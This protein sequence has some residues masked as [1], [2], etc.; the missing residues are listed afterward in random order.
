QGE[1]VAQLADEVEAAVGRAPEVLGEG[2]VRIEADRAGVLEAAPA[3]GRDLQVQAGRR[4]RAA[5]AVAV[6]GPLRAE[7]DL[8]ETRLVA[9]DGKVVAGPAAEPVAHALA[10][11]VR[12]RMVDVR[13]G[14]VVLRAAQDGRTAAGGRA[15]GRRA[16]ARQERCGRGRG[17]GRRRAG[18]DGRQ[19]G[20]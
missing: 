9:L 6:E 17:G 5:A 7:V 14:A 8:V 12:Q 15:R 2:D 20:Q 18:A 16:G 11:G 3:A 4:G 13:P 10:E 1:R 19:A